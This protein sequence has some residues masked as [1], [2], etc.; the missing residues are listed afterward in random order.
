MVLTSLLNRQHPI[1]RNPGP[2]FLVI[3]HHDAVVDPA[4]DEF[5][6]D[7]EEMIRRYAEH[8][9]AQAAETIERY[10]RPLRRE[11]VRQ[12]VHQMHLGAD[13]PDRADRTAANRLDDVF[14]AA[15]VVR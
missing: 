10:D 3:G 12:A 14:G 13:R 9:R 11:L 4:R 5:L 1:E 7:P 2:M 6:Q 15:A 8:R